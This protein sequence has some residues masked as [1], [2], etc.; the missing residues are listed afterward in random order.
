LLARL[1]HASAAT[2]NVAV[3]ELAVADLCSRAASSAHERDG[4]IEASGDS[5]PETSSVVQHSIACP[6]SLLS[7]FL[8]RWMDAWLSRASWFKT[9]V[10]V[11][12]TALRECATE[13]PVPTSRR[14]LSPRCSRVLFT[15]MAACCWPKQD[16]GI[17][18]VGME[19]ECACRAFQRRP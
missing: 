1:S 4:K 16:R 7:G 11:E 3:M 8:S 5:L 13:S 19:L 15:L 6:K 14:R 18:G 9:T 12:V 10:G 17:Q 2:V